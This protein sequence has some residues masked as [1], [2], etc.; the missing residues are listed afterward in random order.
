[1]AFSK[2]WLA[3]SSALW[4]E[5]PAGAG[6]A[7]LGIATESLPQVRLGSPATEQR[8]LGTD[9]CSNTALLPLVLTAASIYQ[10]LGRLSAVRWW[11]SYAL[12]DRET[13]A[14]A[15][16]AARYLYFVSF[17]LCNGCNQAE[18]S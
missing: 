15:T 7:W 17:Y 1:M 9:D 8:V 5:D 12:A 2:T 16:G 3:V 14:V 10:R 6:S 11:R 13:G 18:Q 4:R